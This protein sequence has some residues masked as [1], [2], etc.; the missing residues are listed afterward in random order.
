MLCGGV[1]ENG[2]AG[3]KYDKNGNLNPWWSLQSEEKFKEKTKCMVNQ[4][5][6]YYWKKAGLNVSSGVLA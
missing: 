5:N 6:N 3:R 2:N 4:Y 1:F